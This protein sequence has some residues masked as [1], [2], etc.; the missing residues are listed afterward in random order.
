MAAVFWCLCH[1][2]KCTEPSASY[3]EIPKPDDTET[4]A[5]NNVRKLVAYNLNAA[6]VAQTEE[7]QMAQEPAA[8][9]AK[10]ALLHWQCM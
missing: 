9:P 7:A 5:V 8:G 6:K 10:P 2:N 1:M 4:R 3:F